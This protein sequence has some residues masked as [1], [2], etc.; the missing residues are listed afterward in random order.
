[1]PQL[2]E[3]QG[4]GFK[5][6]SSPG[7]ARRS[8]ASACLLLGAF[9]FG[10]CNA[11]LGNSEPGQLGSSGGGGAV[12]SDGGASGG[13]PSSGGAPA[14]SGGDGSGGSVSG[15]GGDGSGGQLGAEC[16]PACPSDQGCL[17]GSCH[18]VLP[19]CVG[20]SAGTRVCSEDGTSAFACGPTLASRQD[21]SLCEHFCSKGACVQPP[22]C[23]GLPT[24]CGPS[25]S[26]SCCASPLVAGGTFLRGSADDFPATIASFRL[27]KYEVTV[28]RFRKFVA[29]MVGG[30]MPP[31][32]SG[33]HAHLRGSLGLVGTSG[34]DEGGW[35]S[36]WSAGGTT[37]RVF[38]G[39]G[40]ADDWDLSLTCGQDQVHT[41]TSAADLNE[42]LP[43]NCVNW[44]QAAAFCI[45]DGGFLPSEAEWEYAAAGGQLERTYPW[46]T[47]P[48][49]ATRS[50]HDCLGDGS[51][52]DDCLFTDILAV[53]KLPA[54]DGIFG[55][56][57]LAGNMWE[58][59]GDWFS[60]PYAI[61]DCEDC[62]STQAD[63]NEGRSARGGSWMTDATS[64]GSIYRN[65][66]V[67]DSAS[68]FFGVRCARE[69]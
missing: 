31:A 6:V 53:G 1:M 37:Y 38:S 7:A 10:G 63:E 68:E 67:P 58:W 23:I 69:P 60:T 48:P 22:S 25:E 28:G 61:V 42:T 17:S 2:S 47:A 8:A 29:A 15:S 45:W 4:P 13:A 18:P 5:S 21:E 50:A 52:A 56:S 62:I 36:A 39:P 3:R 65:Y 24:T 55:Q 54:G 44:Y 33:K 57:D 35:D 12:G 32:G 59:T 14:A 40:T 9:V 11:L 41:W 34:E 51:A 19:E 43:I 64:Q 46:G 16:V 66:G 26:G 30:W 49:D 20:L 27:D